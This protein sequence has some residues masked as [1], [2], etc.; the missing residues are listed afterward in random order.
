MTSIRLKFRSSIVKGKEGTIHYQV[1][2]RRKAKYIRSDNQLFPNEWDDEYHRVIITGNDERSKYLHHIQEKVNWDIKQLQ[3]IVN[4]KDQNGLDYTVED[5]VSAF[6]QATPAESVFSFIQGQINRLKQ[7]NKLRTAEAY[8]ST[9]NSFRKFREQ[10]DLYFESMDSNMMELYESYLKDKGLVRNSTSF[11]LRILRTVYNQAVESEY[12][13]DK[14]PF[15]HVYTGID[16]TVKRAIPLTYLRKI[17][18]IDLRNQPDL[19]L[20]RDIFLFSFYTRGMSFV[21]IAYLKKSDLKNRIVTYHRKKT[22]Q[23]ISYQWEKQ[24]EEIVSKHRNN[25]SKYMLP[26]IKDDNQDER[27]QYRLALKQINRKLKKVAEKVG[28]HIPL[29]MYVARHSWACIAREQ[30]IPISIISEGMG[31]DS[32]MT[33]KI[34]LTTLNTTVVDQA[35]KKILRIL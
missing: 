17:K 35:N 12:T 21:D 16:K 4:G 34:Y 25:E 33:T 14:K 5:I 3:R 22:G 19:E 23:R 31:H 10:E 1:I 30:S 6:V 13:T 2:H 28:I 8:T 9:L 18:H 20:A 7:Q 26:L 29:T 27:K 15:K 11:Y 32:E 24:M